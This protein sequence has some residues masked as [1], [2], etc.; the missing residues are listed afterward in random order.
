M[1]S[2]Y[3][4]SAVLEGVCKLLLETKIKASRRRW[5][6]PL[7]GGILPPQTITTMS[8]NQCLTRHL[9]FPSQPSL[10]ATYLP[11]KLG[12]QSN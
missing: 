8:R 9:P 7:Q 5:A 10:G 1:A 2:G 3:C 6:E 12:I 11:E 4:I